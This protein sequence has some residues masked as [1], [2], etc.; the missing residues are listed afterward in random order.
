M[1]LQALLA[2]EDDRK[3]RRLLDAR[4]KQSGSAPSSPMRHA[5]VA[6]IPQSP[7]FKTQGSGEVLGGPSSRRGFT[8]EG[9]D[10]VVSEE[11]PVVDN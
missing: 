1:L 2:F 6:T 10:T 8:G 11:K 7:T 9:D 5:P 4:M 3:A